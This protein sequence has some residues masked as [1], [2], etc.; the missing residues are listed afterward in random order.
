[1]DMDDVD[2]GVPSA[3]GR[4]RG[5]VAA[6]LLAKHSRSR[7]PES[8]Q[9]CLILTAVLEVLQGEGMEPTPTALFAAIM[10]SLEKPETQAS[11]QA[12]L[13]YYKCCA[14][15]AP[16]QTHSGVVTSDCTLRDQLTQPKCPIDADW[17]GCQQVCAAMCTILA[18]VIGR[19]PDVVLRSKFAPS[20]AILSAVA[21][22]HPDQVS[23]PL[24]CAHIAHSQSPCHYS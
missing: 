22:R 9:L 19:V 12:R 6:E 23:P 1:M 14:L 18:A 20:S 13:Q 21:E 24:P 7:Q 5:G 15:P 8:Q 10:S 3:R 17:G 11:A 2:F 4:Q 16:S